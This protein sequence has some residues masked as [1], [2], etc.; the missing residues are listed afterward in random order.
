MHG[1]AHGV[2]APEGEGNV[3][4]PAGGEGAGA[5][6]FDLAHRL[7]EID[8]VVVVL[9]H[10]GGDGQDVGIEND[11][12]GI[13]VECA[14]E[15]VVG[16]LADAD[17]VFLCGGLALFVES[18]D[19]D[20]RAV[21]L[22]ELSLFEELVFALLEADGVDDA[23]A[24]SAFEARFD[25]RPLGAIDHD[26]HAGNGRLRGDEV[27][28]LRHAGLGIEEAFVEIDVDNVGSVFHLLSGYGEGAIPVVGL[29]HL[30]EAG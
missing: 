13:E 20:G 8:G 1:L 4:D 14:E 15:Q 25:D 19:D 11:V 22:A 26:R 24:L 6:L 21:A 7:D 17:L 28:E 16:P 12:V 23:F 10:A 18:H 5:D 27:H 30:L 2:V 29:D 9:L 3:T